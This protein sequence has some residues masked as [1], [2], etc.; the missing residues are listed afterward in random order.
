M[1]AIAMGVLIVGAQTRHAEYL[2]NHP[3][4]PHRCSRAPGLSSSPGVWLRLLGA[5]A[6]SNLQ[7]AERAAWLEH[8]ACDLGIDWLVLRIGRSCTQ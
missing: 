1:I 7:A 3:A 6:P 4:L 2:I 8:S 5:C